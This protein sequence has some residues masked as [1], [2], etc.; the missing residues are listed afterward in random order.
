MQ[1]I[2]AYDDIRK[3]MNNFLEFDMQVTAF[4]ATCGQFLITTPYSPENNGLYTN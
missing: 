1:F 2:L 4:N 3:W